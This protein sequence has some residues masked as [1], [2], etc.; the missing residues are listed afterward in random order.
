VFIE[1]LPSNGRPI[2][3]RVVS[4]GNVFNE[5]LPNNGSIY[6]YLVH[7]ISTGKSLKGGGLNVKR[8]H[9]NK[10]GCEDGDLIQLKKDKVSLRDAK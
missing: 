1:P 7:I 9:L 6:H 10:I 2:V 4:H 8:E 3:T 5:P